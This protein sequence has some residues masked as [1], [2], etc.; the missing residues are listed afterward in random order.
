LDKATRLWNVAIILEVSE[1]YKEAEGRLREA[2]EGYEKAVGM[3]YPQTLA[4]MDSLALIQEKTTMEGCREVV[5]AGDTDK[6]AGVRGRPCG[7]A[8]SMVNLAS[9]HRDQGHLKE[10]EKLRGGCISS[11]AKGGQRPVHRRRGGPSHTIFDK[12]LMTLYSSEEEM[13]FTSQK[14]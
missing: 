14:E 9:T 10:M 11:G 2:I 8:G 3:K 5:C 13:I 7:R 12:E 4:G 6:K 1:E